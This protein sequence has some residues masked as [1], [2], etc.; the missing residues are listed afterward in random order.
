MVLLLDVPYNLLWD[1]SELTGLADND[2]VLRV[3][4][5]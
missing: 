1:N 4:L 5:E 3:M 2:P